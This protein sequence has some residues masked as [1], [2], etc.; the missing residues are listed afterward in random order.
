MT[1]RKKTVIS[2]PWYQYEDAKVSLLD[3]MTCKLED[4]VLLVVFVC[5]YEVVAT[6][7]KQD[8]LLPNAKPSESTR[9]LR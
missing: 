1:T 4:L 9:L 2:K 7:L 5:C 3:S 8:L 6:V